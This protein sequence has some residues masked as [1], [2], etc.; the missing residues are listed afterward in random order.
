MKTEIYSNNKI[1]L[2]NDNINSTV[3]ATC[4]DGVV[5][6]LPGNYLEYLPKEGIEEILGDI[7]HN[8]GS[9]L[10]LSRSRCKMV[11]RKIDEKTE[12][13][14]HEYKGN[15]Y[16]L[17]VN[18]GFVFNEFDVYQSNLGIPHDIHDLISFSPIVDIL[19]SIESFVNEYDGNLK[20]DTGLL[21]KGQEIKNI[22]EFFNILTETI[23]QQ[24]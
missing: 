22:K 20:I 9:K 19:L 18:H 7:S 2:K 15:L 10:H 8:G 4:I 1:D 11:F 14:I 12:L 6:L 3:Y 24:L 16:F 17:I 5:E 21:T 23:K 13:H